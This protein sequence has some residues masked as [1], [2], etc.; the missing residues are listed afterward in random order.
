MSGKS[1]LQH[2]LLEFKGGIPHRCIIAKLLDKGHSQERSKL[3]RRGGSIEVLSRNSS[4]KLEKDLDRGQSVARPNPKKKEPLSLIHLMALH[5]TRLLNARVQL[6][7]SDLDFRPLSSVT[8]ALPLTR[9]VPIH[10]DHP[11]VP[12]LPL[13][14]LPPHVHDHLAV[15]GDV[16]RDLAR[17]DNCQ[18]RFGA[19]SR[20]EKGG[21]REGGLT[22]SGK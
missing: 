19:R 16:D 22:L 6:A 12:H 14:R 17:V 18:H 5:Q 8:L 9:H 7:S 3:S 13:I 20:Y 1:T 21:E 10:I 4:K 15:V 2:T 11:L